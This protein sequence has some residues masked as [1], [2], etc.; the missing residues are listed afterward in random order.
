M[1]T[2]SSIFIVFVISMGTVQFLIEVLIMSVLVL[3]VVATLISYFAIKFMVIFRI[4]ISF[5]SL[6]NFQCLLSQNNFQ[7][8]NLLKSSLWYS[9]I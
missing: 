6:F 1:E 5:S 8:I 7:S 2:R 3:A 4:Q 9:P